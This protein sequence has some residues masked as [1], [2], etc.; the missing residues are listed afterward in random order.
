MTINEYL[1]QTGTR[2]AELARLVECD[3]GHLNHICAGRA[4]ASPQLA[5][6]IEAA[7]GGLVRREVLRPDIYPAAHAEA[8]SPE[9]LAA[10]D[11]E[12][13]R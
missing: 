8:F 9:D 13:A 5:L 2:Q 4:K 6:R 10:G 1:E 7:T 12:V 11:V 3:R